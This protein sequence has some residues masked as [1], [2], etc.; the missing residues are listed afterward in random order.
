MHCKLSSQCD[1]DKLWLTPCQDFVCCYALLK[2]FITFCKFFGREHPL[3]VKIIEA[4]NLKNILSLQ[5]MLVHF[6]EFLNL[7]FLC[8][9]NF[10]FMFD[11]SWIGIFFLVCEHHIKDIN[12]QDAYQLR[13]QRDCLMNVIDSFNKLFCISNTRNKVCYIMHFF[14]FPQIKICEYWNLINIFYCTTYSCAFL[15]L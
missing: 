4:S 7:I 14:L 11:S 1:R 13:L 3:R 5:G 15:N 9:Y 12:C 6:S 10:Y 8:F 2:V